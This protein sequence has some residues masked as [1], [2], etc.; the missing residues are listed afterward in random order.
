[1]EIS[2]RKGR[3]GENFN[4]QEGFEFDDFGDLRE[5]RTQKSEITSHKKWL[6]S[7]IVKRSDD[8][9]MEMS[10]RKKSSLF[11]DDATERAKNS[12]GFGQYTSPKFN[13]VEAKSYRTI[14]NNGGFPY[15]ENEVSR[16]SEL[17]QPSHMIESENARKRAS[18]PALGRGLFESQQERPLPHFS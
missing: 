7:D 10:G 3:T 14:P 17:S 5:D 16:L 12:T 11:Q 4:A 9:S 6:P 13:Q 15:P 1:M 18:K 2:G 8:N